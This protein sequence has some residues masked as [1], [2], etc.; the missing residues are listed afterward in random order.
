MARRVLVTR[1]EPEASRTAERLAAL[2]FEPL[3]LPLTR[4]AALPEQSLP[5]G[6]VEAV[7]VTS[8]NALRYA[9]DNVLAALV[10]KPCFAV[11]DK[12]A[13]QARTAGFGSVVSANGDADALAQVV[14][15][16]TAPEARIVY[17]CGVVRRPEFE[18]AVAKA[19][20]TVVPAETYDTLRVQYSDAELKDV[21][22]SRSVDAVLVYSAESGNVLTALI[23]R[24]ITADLLSK[25]LFCCLSARVATALNVESAR[26]RIAERPEQEALFGVLKA[27]G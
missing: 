10:G 9:S 20:R 25:A 4:T 8:F 22:G 12:T 14:I 17:L 16:R 21:L 5:D 18:N 26:I 7:A 13:G 3:V 27:G 24:P 1:P 2:G 19:G 11:G 23:E 6:H 15:S